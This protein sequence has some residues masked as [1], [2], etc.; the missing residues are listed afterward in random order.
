MKPLWITLLLLSAAVGLRSPFP[1]EAAE[2]PISAVSVNGKE[3][4]G[5]VPFIFRA[6]MFLNEQPIDASFHTFFSELKP[7]AMEMIP[8]REGQFSS[9]K[10]YVD[11][12]PSLGTTRWATEAH[13][14]GGR[15][16]IGL[17]EVPRWMQQGG[18]D[19][20]LRPPT[21]WE[22]WARYVE[23]TVRFFNVQL[24][25]DAWYVVW[26][27]PDLEMF[28]KGGTEEDYFKLYRYSVLG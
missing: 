11:R 19:A 12:L 13:K 6:G 22:G 20:N 24:G 1:V 18:R 4:R 25:L 10:E 23:A 7:G 28:W 27:E 3:G 14:K 16:V 17:M 9:L 5:P 2:K 15:P 21:D 8:I 26:D